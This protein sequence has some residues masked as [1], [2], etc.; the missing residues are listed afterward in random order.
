M[1]DIYASV[2]KEKYVG[3]GNLSCLEEIN[4]LKSNYYKITPVDL[5]LNMERMNVPHNINKLFGS[6]IEHIETT[7]DFAKAIKFLYTPEQVVT[8]SY[9]LIFATGYFTDVC[10]QWNQKPEVSK[11]WAEFRIYLWKNTEHGRTPDEKN[12]LVAIVITR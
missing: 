2:L 10:C 6:I 9:N 7:V 1:E 12:E 3:Y 11:T 4:H 8:V 5:K